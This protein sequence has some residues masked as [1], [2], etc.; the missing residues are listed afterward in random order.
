MCSRGLEV[1]NTTYQRFY[2]WF[3]GLNYWDSSSER[4]H[5]TRI[6]NTEVL[7]CDYKSRSSHQMKCDVIYPKIA[8][9][10]QLVTRNG[11]CQIERLHD[12]V[13][14]YAN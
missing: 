7:H 1:Q 13:T 4:L 10:R 11:T 14:K 6:P 9:L 5:F 2:H 3:I 12:D 8:S